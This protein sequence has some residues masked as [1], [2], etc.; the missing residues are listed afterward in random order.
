METI[1]LTYYNE[2]LAENFVVQQILEKE[3]AP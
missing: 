2:I 3:A 1:Y